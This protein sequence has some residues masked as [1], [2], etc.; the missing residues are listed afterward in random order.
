MWLSRRFLFEP[1]DGG[2]QVVEGVRKI[3]FV[4]GRQKAISVGGQTNAGRHAAPQNSSFDQTAEQV[5][6]EPVRLEAESLVETVDPA[7]EMADVL[8]ERPLSEHR[9]GS[10][11]ELL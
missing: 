4:L 9:A 11:G 6:D 7:G 5:S 8:G 10:A 3:G 1:T 2:L